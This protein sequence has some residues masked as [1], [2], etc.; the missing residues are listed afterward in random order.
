MTSIIYTEGLGIIG[1]SVYLWQEFAGP[2]LAS[3]R[4]ARTLRIPHRTLAVSP[5]SA[6]NARHDASTNLPSYSLLQTLNL[7]EDPIMRYLSILLIAACT[8]LAA[9]CADDDELPPT[10]SPPPADQPIVPK[11]GIL[12]PPHVPASPL[13]TFDL[14]LAQADTTNPGLRQALVDS[15][16][17]YWAPRAIPV[18]YVSTDSA[19]GTAA[20]VLTTNGSSAT[21]AGDFNGWNPDSDHLVRLDGTT[22]F[23]VVKRFEKNA[24][25]DYKFV[26]P[27]NNWI[28]DPR[29][30][31]T[32]LGGFGPNSQMWMPSYTPPPEVNTDTTVEHGTA[33][34]FS[35]HSDILNNTRT[36]TVYLPA[37]Y[38]LDTL[39]A[40]PVL[41]THDGPDYRNLLH[42][43]NIADYLSGH[44]DVPPFIVVTVP[45]A[46]PP[47]REGE[48]HMN[49][50]F[51]RFF[52]EELIPYIDAHYSTVA[53][54]E[55][56]AI[57]G[58]SSAGLG[59]VYL[60]W[61]QPDYFKWAIGQ[62]GYYS[63]NGDALMD[64]IAAAPT[65]DLHFYVEVGTYESAVGGGVSLYAAQ[66]RLVTTLQQKGYDYQAIYVPDGHSWGNWQRTIGDAI[67]WM[68]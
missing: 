20:F 24:R 49:P 67:R 38:N 53:S 37:G 35:I 36:V 16:L 62:S 32:L 52:V 7:Q 47:G 43:H 13:W 44:G 50:N 42:I 39:H 18:V 64:S 23:Y 45:W 27:G 33:E 12:N 30:P 19:F 22:L 9:A 40:Y 2:E 65:Y 26:L 29:N 34:T 51:A 58:E 10:N 6:S 60:A 57:V 14:L 55:G 25:F 68:W 1:Q 66:Q 54:R 61:E 59:A 17:A 48:Y 8:V 15:F 56:R 4:R 31:R 11:Q 28:L 21:V 5:T 63:F 41:Y 46:N 3:A